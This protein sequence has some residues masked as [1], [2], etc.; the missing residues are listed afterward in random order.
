MRVKGARSIASVRATPWYV[1]WLLTL[2]PSA[3]ILR[4]PSKPASS[5]DQITRL[6]RIRQFLLKRGVR[7]ILDQFL[8]LPG[9]DRCLD[10]DHERNIRQGRI[11]VNG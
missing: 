3:A 1:Q 11:Y 2:M 10:K 7:L 5:F 8:D 9:K 4:R 6:W